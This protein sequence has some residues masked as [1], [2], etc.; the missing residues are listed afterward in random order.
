MEAVDKIQSFFHALGV[1]ILYKLS[2]LDPTCH[3]VKRRLGL[4]LW[5]LLEN[6]N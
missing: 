1:M 3:H 4:V 2:A 6:K 5:H